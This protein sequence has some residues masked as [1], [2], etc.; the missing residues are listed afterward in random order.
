MKFEKDNFFLTY[1]IILIGVLSFILIY[2]G[3]VLLSKKS[4]YGFTDNVLYSTI[5]MTTLFV[6]FFFVNSV[7]LK[8]KSIIMRNVYGIVIK[9]FDVKEIKARKVYQNYNPTFLGV[10][11]KKYNNMIGI[12]FTINQD[13]YSISGQIFSNNGLKQMLSKTKK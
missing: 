7:Q 4:D 8:N 12:K 10:F 1:R 6:I 5:L 9:K 11:G 2:L 13:K 3:N